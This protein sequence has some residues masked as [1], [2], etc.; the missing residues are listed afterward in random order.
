MENKTNFFLEN[1]IAFLCIIDLF[2]FDKI[3]GVKIRYIYRTIPKVS[4]R[5]T[6][7][8]GAHFEK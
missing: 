1:I 2:A 5:L 4:P 3:I 6:F 8:V 7:D